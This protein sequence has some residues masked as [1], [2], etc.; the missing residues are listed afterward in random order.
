MSNC[1][2]CKNMKTIKE[3]DEDGNY[4]NHKCTKHNVTVRH[5]PKR[6]LGY[7]WH[8]TECNEKDFIKK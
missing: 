1:N 7:I 8:C 5:S 4:T 2:E 6:V 3:H